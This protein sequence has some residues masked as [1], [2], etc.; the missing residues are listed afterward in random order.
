MLYQSESDC[1]KMTY[2]NGIPYCW[3]Y[4]AGRKWLDPVCRHFLSI[5]LSDSVIVHSIVQA[6]QSLHVS[7][8]II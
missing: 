3:R 8:H 6:R 2:R 4:M 1:H 5:N 7:K